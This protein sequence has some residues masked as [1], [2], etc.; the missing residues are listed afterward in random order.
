MPLR[1]SGSIFCWKRG[2]GSAVSN[3]SCCIVCILTARILSR[4]PSEGKIWLSPNADGAVRPD[5]SRERLSPPG[6][7]AAPHFLVFPDGPEF[8]SAAGAIARQGNFFVFN[9]DVLLV[10]ARADLSEALLLRCLDTI[11]YPIESLTTTMYLV[12]S[13]KVLLILTTQQFPTR[14][15]EISQQSVFLVLLRSMFICAPCSPTICV[16]GILSSS[17]PCIR[18]RCICRTAC[19]PWLRVRSRRPPSGNS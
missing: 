18:R 13:P 6:N 3:K 19:M 11:L 4:H 16:S 2:G 14:L 1:N 8:G 5:V 7:L 17:T 15:Q 9:H 10:I 12:L